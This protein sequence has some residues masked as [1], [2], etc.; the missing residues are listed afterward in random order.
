[1]GCRAD[2]GA[3]VR[4]M[5][6]RRCPRRGTRGGGRLEEGLRPDGRNLL[7][8]PSNARDQVWCH[9]GVARQAARP[10]LALDARCALGTLHATLPLRPFWTRGARWPGLPLRAGWPWRAHQ[11][12]DARGALM[13]EEAPLSLRPADRRLALLAPRARRTGGPRRSRWA[14]DARLTLH[15]R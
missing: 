4:Q 6:H 13:T 5:D 15:S 14:C 8:D 10:G 2:L 12:L 7:L 3:H 11:A 1:R 9:A